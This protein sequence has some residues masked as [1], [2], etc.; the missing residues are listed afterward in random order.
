[1]KILR[2][3][4]I[5]LALCF[6]G[7]FAIFLYDSNTN[8]FV[9]D[10]SNN[11][12]DVVEFGGPKIELSKIQQKL[13]ESKSILA[14]QKNALLSAKN[15]KERKKIL[16]SIDF[17]ENEIPQIEACIK[18][19]TPH[20]STQSST[21]DKN[22]NKKDKDDD[23]K[24]DIKKEIDCD[25][26]KQQLQ[27]ALNEKLAL[28]SQEIESIKDIFSI[29]TNKPPEEKRVEA[30]NIIDSIEKDRREIFNKVF[31]I[32]NTFNQ[33]CTEK[34]TH[35]EKQI[36]TEAQKQKSIL[37][38]LK[39][40]NQN[41][42]NCNNKIK[43]IND[44]ID[45]IDEIEESIGISLL[46][47]ISSITGFD[48]INDISSRSS[49][50]DPFNADT[51]KGVETL[52][53]QGLEMIRFLNTQI[54]AIQE[55]CSLEEKK[56]DINFEG[57]F[58]I[59]LIEQQQAQALE[60]IFKEKPE[61]IQEKQKQ[62]DNEQFTQE[63]ITSLEKGFEALSE[64]FVIIDQKL[65]NAEIDT[66]IDREQ[67]VQQFQ[68]ETT[69]KQSLELTKHSLDHL[70]KTNK[71]L[72]KVSSESD[73][74]IK[75]QIQQILEKQSKAIVDTINNN[76]VQEKINEAIKQDSITLEKIQN[77][78]KQNLIN[79]TSYFLPIIQ[80][81]SAEDIQ[82][83]PKCDSLQSSLTAINQDK[84]N[85]ES[86][87]KQYDILITIFQE[88]EIESQKIEEDQQRLIQLPLL[89]Q[90][91]IE[92]IQDLLKQCIS[93]V[94]ILKT[95]NLCQEEKKS[96]SIITDARCDQECNIDLIIVHRIELDNELKNLN[97]NLSLWFQSIKEP[98]EISWKNFSQNIQQHLDK[99]DKAYKKYS[100][101]VTEKNTLTCVQN[102]INAMKSGLCYQKNRCD[103][104]QEIES[105]FDIF[106]TESQK[107]KSISSEILKTFVEIINITNTKNEDREL[108]EQLQIQ[109]NSLELYIHTLIPTL[110]QRNI[111]RT[112]VEQAQETCL[113][114]I[115]ILKGLQQCTTDGLQTSS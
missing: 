43:E 102:K 41:S 55:F 5:T 75:N 23:K 18:L 52:I 27:K 108:K 81:A 94:A 21:E 34:K 8:W 20:Q 6:I 28:S 62:F 25:D 110:K 109:Q 67:E 4:L 56:E 99:I 72:Q 98:P 29:D 100:A 63:E 66:F 44:R 59:L 45:D 83:C 86:I 82:A 88:L 57:S 64:V 69:T 54:E 105:Y 48:D 46:T 80:N 103:A 114:D 115:K 13:A 71:I 3:R 47:A 65:E 58:E 95:E 60:N 50:E 97:D 40:R 10:I 73:I 24:D 12:C 33:N 91:I 101:S 36:K 51:L 70:N 61:I 89:R 106:L 53:I 38:I 17:F 39:L 113:N 26:L 22:N 79:K 93:N 1:M 96:G 14:E 112:T 74:T 9:G 15:E 30:K 90:E 84:E 19:R 42:V 11:P 35:F 16:E 7:I 2:V 76:E 32:Q 68:L 104:C 31:S 107:Y 49:L 85:I 111:I 77:S 37:D 87:I 78:F 92:K